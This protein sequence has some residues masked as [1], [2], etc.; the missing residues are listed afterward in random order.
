MMARLILLIGVLSLAGLSC[1]DLGNQPKLPTGVQISVQGTTVTEGQT[2]RIVVTLS[3]PSDTAIIF[4]V[5]TISGL[6]AS[7][8]DYVSVVATDTIAAGAAKDTV[9]ISTVDDAL[10]ESSETFT[11]RVSNLSSGEFTDSVATVTIIDNDGGVTLIKFS[12][13]IK[14]LLDGNCLRCHGG[15]VTNS[16]FSVATYNLIM[17]SGLRGPNVVAFNSAG[18]RLYI[19]TTTSPTR[20][21]D[22]MPFGGPYLTTQQQDLIK[23]WIDQGALNN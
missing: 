21:I 13:D 23:T 14:P 20:D 12:T 18:S 15:E 3:Q 2:A 22:R 1:K 9:P 10:P 19:A 11:A 6:A 4:D 17:T 5:A 7:G 16:G 8:T